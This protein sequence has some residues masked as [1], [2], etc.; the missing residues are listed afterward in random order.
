MCKRIQRKNRE[1]TEELKLRAQKTRCM[2]ITGRLS[3]K[4]NEEGPLK[5]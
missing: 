2:Y 4:T 3:Y 5:S 1:T